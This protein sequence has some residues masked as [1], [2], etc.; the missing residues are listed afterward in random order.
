MLIYTRYIHRGTP[1]SA[2]GANYYLT[3]FSALRVIL[4]SLLFLLLYV[5]LVFLSAYVL[6][7]TF[8]ELNND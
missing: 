6:W 7:V 5:S 4:S 1:W 3:A 8:P 2:I